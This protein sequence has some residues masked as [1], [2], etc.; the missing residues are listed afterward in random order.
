M[1]FS[2]GGLGGIVSAGIN[3]FSAKDTNRK[4]KKLAREQMGF[5]ERMSNTAY[6]R[7]VKDMRAAGIN[8]MLAY[9][10]GGASTPSGAQPNLKAPSVGDTALTGMEV[11]SKT[12]QR[13][14]Q[15]QNIIKQNKLIDAQTD[16]ANAQA[17][18]ARGLAKQQNVIGDYYLR[19]PEMAPLLDKA[20]AAGAMAGSAKS[21]VETW[22]RL[23]RKW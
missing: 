17:S 19:Y 1:G 7:A 14:L 4:A 5:Q 12:T 23:G 20:G 2:L 11:G 16:H 3:Y 18:S 13:K 6:Q 15:N 22:K 10:Q 21:L 8:P 9:A